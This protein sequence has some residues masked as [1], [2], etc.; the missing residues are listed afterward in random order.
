MSQQTSL[1]IYA[2]DK[3]TGQAR[4][5][6]PG[7]EHTEALLVLP[8]RDITQFKTVCCQFGKIV[9]RGANTQGVIL[10]PYNSDAAMRALTQP[11][12]GKTPCNRITV[13]V[14]EETDMMEATVRYLST[15]APA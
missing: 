9:E 8:L 11:Q 13:E 6:T 2:W 5:A 10:F 15:H 14:C 3:A 7:A 1:P 4:L 12:R